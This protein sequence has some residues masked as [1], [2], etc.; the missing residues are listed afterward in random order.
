MYNQYDTPRKKGLTKCVHLQG[1]G[2]DSQGVSSTVVEMLVFCLVSSAISSL[3]KLDHKF[4]LSAAPQLQWH[5]KALFLAFLTQD[6]AIV[7][8]S[9]V[10]QPM[11][12]HLG[13]SYVSSMSSFQKMESGGFFFLNIHT[14][15]NWKYQTQSSNC[16][17]FRGFCHGHKLNH[18]QKLWYSVFM[19]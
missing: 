15:L 6:L 19:I 1:P 5:R 17:I 3:G 16:L 4:I 2:R 13:L 8:F 7:S 14:I 12:K 11:V 18:G 9:K 10:W